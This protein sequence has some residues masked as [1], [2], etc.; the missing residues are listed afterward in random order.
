MRSDWRSATVHP[1]RSI[2]ISSDAQADFLVDLKGRPVW[3]IIGDE[4]RCAL[5]AVGKLFS[6]GLRSVPASPGI[7]KPRE[8]TVS[9]IEPDAMH[10]AQLY[11]HLT[12]RRFFPLHSLADLR[13]EPLP[14]VLL[15]TL[16]SLTPEL[17]E[18]LYC[19]G[20]SA[21]G[22]IAADDIAGLRRQALVRSAAALLGRRPPLS[23]VRS[24]MI[25]ATISEVELGLHDPRTGREITSEEDLRVRLSRGSPVLTMATHGD[26]IDAYLGKFALCPLVCRTTDAYPK[27][28]PTCVVNSFCH[29]LESPLDAAL[30][31]GRLIPPGDLAARIMVFA[32]CHGVMVSGSP[33]DPAWG[34]APGL[35]NNPRI[36]A[37]V[38]T[39]E[40]SLTD[41][42]VSLVEL[43]RQLAAGV[44][45]G[46][47]VAEFNRSDA[48]RGRGCR[49]VLFGD[50]SVKATSLAGKVRLDRSSRVAK[51]R[52]QSV[53]TVRRRN[54]DEVAFLR[55]Y[56]EMEIA[57]PYV[58]VTKNRRSFADPIQ[59]GAQAALNAVNRYR[60]AKVKGRSPGTLVRLEENMHSAILVDSFWQQRLVRSWIPY[61]RDSHIGWR[62]TRCWGCQA[63]ARWAVVALGVEG[64]HPRRLLLCPRCGIVEDVASHVNMRFS[65]NLQRREIR[66]SGKLP[67]GGWQA[68]VQLQSLTPKHSQTW[69]WPR[70]SNGRPFTTWRCPSEWPIGPVR[71]CFVMVHNASVDSIARW[72]YIDS[73]S[74]L[75]NTV[76]A[77]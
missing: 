63:P 32:T 65:L 47:A 39:W 61:V 20:S 33:V 56:L 58:Q 77:F 29:R 15:T 72:V 69:T 43:H 11:A 31:S 66:L 49:L 35:L 14:D 13:R 12:Q 21:T 48:A 30:R 64:T 52:A 73:R 54:F 50:P 53:G 60:D 62:S 23:S 24:T 40:L 27:R 2:P 6:S 10:A 4:D 5:A 75:P 67:V 76:E 42:H 41:D 44:A 74:P 71:I 9:A 28:P 57:T 46:R 19:S 45:V 7:S 26:G 59:A 38:T 70:K 55:A 36:G 17:M 1:A 3:P 22:I 51:P 68:A 16:R 18:M 25:S 8:G 34:L 37:L